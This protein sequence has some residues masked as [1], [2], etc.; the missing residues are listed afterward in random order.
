MVVIGRTPAIAAV[1]TKA[2]PD[3]CF[4][5]VGGR[6]TNPP[7][8]RNPAPQA[9]TLRNQILVLPPSAERFIKLHDA[10]DFIALQLRQSQLG[11]E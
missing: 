1:T 2:A 4:A 8:V 9:D 6:V 10:Q 7:Q 3:A 11:L 5:S